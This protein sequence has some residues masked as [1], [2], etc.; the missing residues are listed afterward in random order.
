MPPAVARHGAGLALRCNESRV[1]VVKS[2]RGF[3]VRRNQLPCATRDGAMFLLA[4][5]DT[6]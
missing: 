5:A 4:A 6:H 3:L 2:L 1:G